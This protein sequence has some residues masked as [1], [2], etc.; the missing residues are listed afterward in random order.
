MSKMYLKF[1]AGRKKRSFNDHESQRLSA[2]K[3]IETLF[4]ATTD[5]NGHN[6]V[7][8]IM[9]EAAETPLHADGLLGEAI[10]GMLLPSH[11]L[12]MMPG[13]KFTK[14]HDLLFFWYL[15]SY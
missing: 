4:E 5:L 14:C 7:L 3:N 15:M 13:E 12:D 11:L 9:C 1:S 6:C 8:R 10:N 2:L